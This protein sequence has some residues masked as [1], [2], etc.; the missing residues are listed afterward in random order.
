MASPFK[1]TP[2]IKALNADPQAFEQTYRAKFEKKL[3]E[4]DKRLQKECVH[5]HGNNREQNHIVELP[6]ALEEEDEE[7]GEPEDEMFRT[8]GHKEIIEQFIF[9]PQLGMIKREIHFG[10]IDYITTF[11]LMKKIEEKIKI[12]YQEEPSSVHPQIYANR[13]QECI[14]RIF[15]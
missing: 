2:E 9:D 8:L 15:S 10:I 1:D 5:C 7:I 11:N 14:K 12:S 4:I 6:E 13:F 3:A